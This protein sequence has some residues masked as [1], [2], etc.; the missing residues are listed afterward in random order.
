[1]TVTIEADRIVIERAGED[2]DGDDDEDE[3]AAE[4]LRSTRTPSTPSSRRRRSL[5][6]GDCSAPPAKSDASRA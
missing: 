4:S 2:A 3:H 6:V 1:M 5:L